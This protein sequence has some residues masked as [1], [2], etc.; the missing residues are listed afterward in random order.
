MQKATSAVSRTRKYV[1][2]GRQIP[3]A[4]P[5]FRLLQGYPP[6]LPSRGDPEANCRY[7]LP[8]RIP[9]SQ[10]SSCNPSRFPRNRTQGQSA[11]KTHLSQNGYCYLDNAGWLLAAVTAK[12]R[13]RQWGQLLMKLNSCVPLA[14][15]QAGTVSASVHRL[16]GRN[17]RPE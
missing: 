1:L 13:M 16:E 14:E 8:I 6:Q 5:S 15:R 12:S 2:D 11:F 9:R 3:I 7:V 17:V 10:I 4:R